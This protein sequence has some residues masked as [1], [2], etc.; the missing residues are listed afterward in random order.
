MRRNGRRICLETMLISN[1][2]LSP[3]TCRCVIIFQ[4]RTKACEIALITLYTKKQKLLGHR[5][6]LLA[7]FVV[8][9]LFCCL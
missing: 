3:V 5:K 6:I 9:S 4:A 2:E 7:L 1:V 8:G